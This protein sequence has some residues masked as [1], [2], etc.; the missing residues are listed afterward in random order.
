[1]KTA[2]NL[3]GLWIIGAFLFFSCGPILAID[4][5]TKPVNLVIGF[6]AGGGTDLLVRAMN[7][8]LSEQL[9]VP[10]IVLNKP[11]SGG[12][13]AGEFVAKSK[14]DGYNILVIATPHLLRQIID[15]QMPFDVFR[16]LSPVC[17][18]VTHQM[19]LAVE[20]GSKFKTV[21]DLLDFARTNPGKLSMG[22]PG[23]GSIGHFAGELFK[24]STR[25]SF[26]H[27]PFT[28]MP[29]TSRR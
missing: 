11:G 4:F 3:F 26:K 13:V 25:V 24:A 8:K 29:P 10:A 7:D 14:P 6:A 27:V 1:M 15:F 2:K 22:S 21:E 16:D 5:P 18:F 28:G 9:G 17:L 19:V 12:L 23:V 20:K